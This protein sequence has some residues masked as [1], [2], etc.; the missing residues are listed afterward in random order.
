[1]R[2][3][4]PQ[5][6]HIL[7]AVGEPEAREV[8]EPEVRQRRWDLW[9][10]NLVA[11]ALGAALFVIGFGWH[12]GRLKVPLGSG[13]MLQP[14]VIAKLWGDHTPFGNNT[15][16]YP[17]GM[18]LSYF[19]TADVT[20]NT[21]AGAI[22]AITHNP[23]LGINLVHALSFPIVALAAL[24][25][26]RL[27]GVRGPVAIVSSLAFTAIPFHWLRLEHFYLGTIYS[28]V[29]G[30]GLALLIGSGE[31]ARRLA[32]ERRRATIVLLVLLS[33]V[34]AT[35]GI[36][37]ACFAI[38]LC[39]VALLHHYAH[40]P[41]K[42]AL[43]FSATPI[44]GFIFFTAVALAPAF[45]FVRANPAL[46]PVAERVPLESVAYSGN[47][48]FL[49]TPAP[50][51]QLPGLSLL[52]P[53]IENAFQTAASSS[54]SGVSLLSNFGSYFTLLA[55]GFALFGLFMSTRAR[56]R[57]L[58]AATPPTE[59]SGSKTV[60]FGL[61]GTLL[62]TGILFYVPWGL[63]VVFAS[64]VTPQIRAWDRLTPV[65]LLLFFVGA[66]VAWRTL[67]LP[68][69]TRVA[70]VVSVVLL[71]LLIPDSIAPYQQNYTTVFAYG[72]ANYTMGTQYAAALN[73]AIPGDCGILQLPY[74]PYPEYPPTNRLS[75]Y[76]GFQAPLTNPE[77][78][79][80]YGA[81]KNSADSYWLQNLGSNVDASAVAA[82][83]AGGFCGV[84]VD[85][86]GYTSYEA[87]LVT[88]R[89]DDVLGS[90]VATGHKGDWTAWKI[91]GSGRGAATP[92]DIGNLPDSAKRFFY[93]PSI[94]P[95]LASGLTPVLDT[96]S[97]EW[98]IASDGSEFDVR[99]AQG[100]FPFRAIQGQLV[101][102]PCSARDVTVELKSPDQV[103]TTTVHLD[104]NGSG[105][106][107]VE[108]PKDT[109]AATLAV[110]SSGTAC[111]TAADPRQLTVALKDPTAS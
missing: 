45:L 59:E 80:T 65:L 49:L 22:A 53:R 110:R 3:Q 62:V 5:E 108:L 111:P 14:Y 106:F 66:M 17:F 35:S 104:P 34:V 55:L 23:F 71:A 41:S 91:P 93:P 36:Y 33:A 96:F 37:Y 73:R 31:V 90:P 87:K 94:E 27:V 97:T 63:N 30:V 72:S 26:F 21:V 7:V 75:T 16:G 43:A 52:N 109:R 102:A 58:R 84:H 61:V 60:T 95:P 6:S 4:Q 92:A 89:L 105:D 12:M 24:W 25:V 19:P 101:A 68:Q 67:R 56:T 39:M 18:N 51:T 20:Q 47:L 86:R 83:A 46:Q 103:M 29:I 28:A 2:E 15:F 50:M 11:A 77:K 10:E 57:D 64:L 81:T 40:D 54:Q 69:R 74:I 88:A 76:D 82:L 107:R 44:V 42:R 32:G 8:T 38:L 1:M 70:T 98:W 9:I 13:D 85:A 99:S 100:G 48:A 78:R 79:W